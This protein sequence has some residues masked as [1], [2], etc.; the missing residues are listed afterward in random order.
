MSTPEEYPEDS[1]LNGLIELTDAIRQLEKGLKGISEEVV[2][3]RDLSLG[4]ADHDD[5]GLFYFNCSDLEDY[6][7]QG[8]I[9][10]SDNSGELAELIYFASEGDY[11]PLEH[12]EINIKNSEDREEI[13]SVID[14][15]FD[16]TD[17]F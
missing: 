14:G 15:S 8:R 13:Y 6:Q 3:K 1:D 2:E 12:K 16:W 17:T 4:D 7:V 9:D 11:R 5:E 10:Y